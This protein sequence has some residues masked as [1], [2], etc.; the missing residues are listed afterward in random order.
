MSEARPMRALWLMNHTTLRR[1]EVPLLQNLGLEVFLPKSFPYDEGN[2]SASVTY[3]LDGGLSIPAA[4]LAILNRTNFYEALPP[5]IA[6]IINRHFDIAFIGYFPEQLAALARS[7]EGVVVMRAFGLANGMTYGAVTAASLGRSFIHELD[8]LGRRFWFGQ[9][10]PGLADIETGVFKR[11]AVHLPLGLAPL[12][13]ENTW[14]GGDKKILLVCPRIGSS[15]YYNAVYR[16]FRRDFHGFDYVIGGAQPL[17]VD[18]PNVMGFLSRDAFDAMMKHTQVMYYHSQEQY[19]IHYHPF[20]AVATGM[21]LIFM[22]NGM[23]DAIGGAMLPGRA[24][25]IRDARKKVERILGDDRSFIAEVVGTQDILLRTMSMSFCEP[26]WQAG[27]SGIRDAVQA[28]KTDKIQRPRAK[29]VAVILPEAYRGGTLDVSKLLAKM[30]KRGSAVAGEAVEVVFAHPDNSLYAPEDFADLVKENIPRRPF[31]WRRLTRSDYV[32][33]QKIA[34]RIGDAGMENYV[35]PD[36]G[37][38]FLMDCDLWLLT[39]D[40][41]PEPLAPVRPYCLF[42]QDYLQRYCPDLLGDHYEQAFIDTARDASAVL[43]N[44]PHAVEDAVQYAGLRRNRIKMVPHVVDLDKLCPDPGRTKDAPY[45]IWATNAGSHKKP[46]QSL[47]A[48]ERYFNKLG[49]EAYNVH[50]TGFNTNLF[51]PRID[52]GGDVDDIHLIRSFVNQSKLLKSRVVFLGELDDAS[53][54]TQLANAQFLFH[55]AAM[56]NGTL[57]SVEAAYLN[58][59]TLSSDYPPMRFLSDRYQLN[60]RFMRQESLSDVVDNLVSATRELTA[61]RD[62]LPSREFLDALGWRQMAGQFWNAI[63]EQL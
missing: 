54:S 6:A 37:V 17:P 42:V 52:Y 16:K 30:I 23:L 48:F 21:P 40:R 63:K 12:P 57:C 3:D 7:F 39:T 46:I 60:C 36:D 27:F 24:T 53:Y 44:T 4:D 59:P 43:V 18:D 26:L 2:L 20:E 32:L 1:F 28:I 15:P 56:D 38:N 25:S 50:V 58:V 9:A 55:N 41:L 51:D 11:R 29:R 5:D 31:S 49:D 19:H 34:R 45:I 33:A 14:V 13:Q 22:S 35:V 62:A 8:N 10:Y 47:Q 61:W